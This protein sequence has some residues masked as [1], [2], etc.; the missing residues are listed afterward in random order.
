MLVVRRGLG[1]RM[2]AAAAAKFTVSVIAA[3]TRVAEQRAGKDGCDQQYGKCLAQEL[4]SPQ[5]GIHIHI[6]ISDFMRQ[7]QLLR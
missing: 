2:A 7:S 5:G 6:T 3:V 4:N 1:L